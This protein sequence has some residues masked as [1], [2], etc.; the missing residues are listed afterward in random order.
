MTA[1]P[2]L[3]T[4]RPLH[5]RHSWF[6]MNPLTEPDGWNRGNPPGGVNREGGFGRPDDGRYLGRMLRFSTPDQ[7][8]WNVQSG[9]LLRV[10]PPHPAPIIPHPVLVGI[11]ETLN[12]NP[13]INST[14]RGYG[15]YSYRNAPTSG[16]I[17][18]LTSNS[19][20]AVLQRIAM[21]G[22]PAGAYV[23]P[24]AGQRIAFGSA[25]GLHRTWVCNT[26][27]HYQN[28]LYRT[29]NHRRD[30]L[31]FHD[32][33][34]DLS[35][36][37]VST[38]KDMSYH[39]SKFF[40]AHTLNYI[41]NNQ[42]I[43]D[44]RDQA[45]NVGKHLNLH[46]VAFC[47][48]PNPYECRNLPNRYYDAHARTLLDIFG[49]DAQ[50]ATRESWNKMGFDNVLAAFMGGGDPYD[51]P[52]VYREVPPA[53]P[54][55][56]PTYEHLSFQDESA[57]NEM[58]LGDNAGFHNH[59][60]LITCN[61]SKVG[62]KH[63]VSPDAQ[64]G[65]RRTNEFFE[66]RA[67]GSYVMDM[68][69]SSSPSNRLKSLATCWQNV[70]DDFEGQL[71]YLAY[72]LCGKGGTSTSYRYRE[73]ANTALTGCNLM[74]SWYNNADESVRRNEMTQQQYELVVAKQAPSRTAGIAFLP[75]RHIND[76]PDC[77]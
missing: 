18:L 23:P 3:S 40:I 60:A 75:H 22:F 10:H 20:P 47:I 57:S 66:F 1:S 63:M 28:V 32:I 52:S 31:E 51:Q 69:D 76:I 49:T 19:V 27:E 13:M 38:G 39:Q 67:H 44:L 14:H 29:P 2:S 50:P 12:F 48:K 6:G 5:P 9:S 4:S 70:D 46:M 26:M 65:W 11:E 30:Y 59:G 56:P 74:N 54:G 42:A 15:L 55:L 7:Y 41:Y 37:D 73:L 24:A 71:R 25:S 77:M 33:H 62:H 17:Q 36:I 45:A 72:A 8:I 58:I 43:Q 68:P 64:K 61:L 35:F 53:A 34:G 16:Q 21:P